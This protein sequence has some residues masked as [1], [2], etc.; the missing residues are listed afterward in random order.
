MV[1]ENF[2]G[3][4]EEMSGLIA[5][6]ADRIRKLREKRKSGSTGAFSI[7]TPSGSASYDQNG[8][9]FLRPQE[10]GNIVQ[11]GGIIDQIKD[12]PILLIAPLAIIGI[13]LMKRN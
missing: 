11:S 3:E 5:N 9:Q 13:L 12:N 8:I 7:N 2:S 1:L 10:G 6:I 4:T